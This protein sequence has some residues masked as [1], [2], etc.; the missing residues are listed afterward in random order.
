MRI[1]DTRFAN[2]LP[3]RLAGARIAYYWNPPPDARKVFVGEA[4]GDETDMATVME[5]W[6][7]AEKRLKS[8]RAETKKGNHDATPGPA[9]STIDF[10]L[11]KEYYLSSW[12]TKTVSEGSRPDYVNK[13]KFICGFRLANGRRFGDMPWASIEPTHGDRLFQA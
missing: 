10:L 9:P 12:Y 4:L 2:L 3:K 1:G 5:R 13:F 8:W 11:Q 6:S 7:A